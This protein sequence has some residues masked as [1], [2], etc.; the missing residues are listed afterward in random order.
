MRTEGPTIRRGSSSGEHGTPWEFI[1]ALQYHYD[2][3]FEIDLAATAENTKAPIYLSPQDNSLSRSWRLYKGLCWL[4]PPFADIAPWVE[5][6]A[7]EKL[8][9][10]R[11]LLLVPASI[12]ANWYWDWVHDYASVYSIGR[13]TFE[14]SSDPYP[15]DLM[16]CEYDKRRAVQPLRRLNWKRFAELT[17]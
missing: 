8:Y 11:I 4:N 5:K 1:R 10:A 6:C 12:G 15:K 13:L 3:R 9:G 14:G 7:V 2:E 17:A 16:L